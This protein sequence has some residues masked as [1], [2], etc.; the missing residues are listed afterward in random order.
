MQGIVDPNLLL[1]LA[2]AFVRISAILALLPLFGDATVPVRVRILL[3]VAVTIAVSALL[4]KM[5]V[6]GNFGEAM[7]LAVL[8]IYQILLGAVLGF[9]TRII[10]DAILMA[11]NI[12]AYQMGFGTSSL[13]L[14]DLN[15]SVDSFTL[16]HRML[17]MMIFLALSLHHVWIKA[18]ADSF[19]L[20]PLDPSILRGELGVLMV[21]ATAGIFSTS[22]QLAAPL[23]VALL[24]GMAALGLVARI[25]PQLNVFAMSF[26]ISFALGLIIYVATLP[27]FPEW[28]RQN[29][30]LE[31]ER[32]AS[33]LRILAG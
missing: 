12:V 33:S 18:I 5:S 28:L 13:F 7:S 8:V 25:V 15:L 2:V 24:F 19:T 6:P 21:Q 16:M 1:P 26:P 3:A 11:A 32:L 17:V 27:L 22:L 9:L 20:L 29:F 4:P 14:P 23:L 10:F 30:A 31:S